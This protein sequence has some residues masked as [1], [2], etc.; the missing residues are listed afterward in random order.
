PLGGCHTEREGFGRAQSLRRHARLPVG[1]RAVRPGMYLRRPRAIERDD[2]GQRVVRRS[3]KASAERRACGDTHG[4]QCV[5]EPSGR[6]CTFVALV[7]SNETT[8]VSALYV[9]ARRLQPSAERAETTHGYQCVSEPSGRLY[10][11]VGRARSNEAISVSA[12]KS[13]V[14]PS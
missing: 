1:K 4:Y 14:T 7:R 6:V 5:N 10:T 8:S 11:F 3:A 13:T 12:L 2:F 9:V